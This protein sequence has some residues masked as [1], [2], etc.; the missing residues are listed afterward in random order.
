VHTL[1]EEYHKN[2]T[3]REKNA[4]VQERYNA[5]KRLQIEVMEADKNEKPPAFKK[6]WLGE[7]ADRAWNDYHEAAVR[8][9]VYVRSPDDAKAVHNAFAK[10]LKTLDKKTADER[11][12]LLTGRLRGKERDELAAGPVLT[13]MREA[14]SVDETIYLVATS[15]GEVGADLDADHLVCDLTTADALIQ[16][17]GR[18]NRRGQRKRKDASHIDLVAGPDPEPKKDAGE[19][20]DRWQARQ[21]TLRLLQKLPTGD[22]GRI[23]ASPLATRECWNITDDCRE[24]APETLPLTESMVS[25]LS[26]TSVDRTRLVTVRNNGRAEKRRVPTWPLLPDVATLIHGLVEETAEAT[27]AWRAEVSFLANADLSDEETDRLAKQVLKA[28]PVRAAERLTVPAQVAAK[29]ITDRAKNFDGEELVGLLIGRGIERLRLNGS[30]QASNLVGRTLLLPPAF[31]GLGKNGMLDAA[32]KTPT[33][34]LDL[35]DR[36]D[37]QRHLL[38]AAGDGFETRPL[39]A[40]D[41]AWRPID[42][43]LHREA[44]ETIRAVDGNDLEGFTRRVVL[45][46]READDQETRLDLVIFR[47]PST[48]SRGPSGRVRLGEHNEQVRDRAERFAEALDLPNLWRHALETA[49]ER[50]DTGK[51]R[52]LWQTY[53]GNLKLSDPVAKPVGRRQP[54]WTLLDGYRHEYGSLLDTIAAGIDDPLTLHLIASHHAWARPHFV[55]PID[56]DLIGDPPKAAM[57][58]ELARRFDALQKQYGPWG[59]AWLEA[60]LRSADRTVSAG[61]AADDF[62]VEEDADA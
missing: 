2:A 42:L 32:T 59:L 41:D 6:R 33:P 46:L 15:A 26:M 23:D 24:P 50:H 16:R 7:L 36:A 13:A 37:V 27:L 12:A 18:V 11:L 17:L 4:T 62:D 30:V 14:K 19:A 21:A 54:D 22:D 61:D 56:P 5:H 60:L 29:W 45:P 53:A 31:G 43:A 51:S 44:V 10:R 3:A 48:G 40:K 49:A 38:R 28:C 20:Y 47:K 8:V 57:P 55:K 34:Q 58:L 52:Y 39:A 1:D 9:I 25:A 35:G